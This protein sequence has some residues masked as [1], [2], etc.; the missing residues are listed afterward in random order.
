MHSRLLEVYFCLARFTSPHFNLP[1]VVQCAKSVKE[2]RGREEEKKER[3]KKKGKVSEQSDATR[4]A[5]SSSSGA[6]KFCSEVVGA[7]SSSGVMPRKP[8]FLSLPLFLVAPS[9]RLTRASSSHPDRPPSHCRVLP[10]PPQHCRRRRHYHD[11]L[12]RSS[13]RHLFSLLPFCKKFTW[14]KQL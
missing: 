1:H 5:A 7:V 4:T 3:R 2:G 6:V 9:L 8:T 10:L 13:D 12:H 14:V 11:R